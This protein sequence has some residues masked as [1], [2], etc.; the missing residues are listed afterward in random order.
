SQVCSAS[1]MVMPERYSS[2]K[3]FA[4]RAMM[5]LCSSG[6]VTGRCS[7]NQSQAWRA[8]GRVRTAHP[9][10]AAS[11]AGNSSSNGH[12]ARTASEMAIITRVCTGSAMP[13]VRSRPV[14][15]GTR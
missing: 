10:P 8:A 12:H 5:T 11:S 13:I 4:K 7:L 9:A 15:W 1:R 14:T 6:P 3:T 2:A